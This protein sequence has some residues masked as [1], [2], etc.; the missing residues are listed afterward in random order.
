MET[1]KRQKQLNFYLTEQEWKD[2]KRYRA[3]QEDERSISAMIRD[4]IKEK[5]YDNQ[6]CSKR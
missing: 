2:V 6:D 3:R 4:M 5:I 1:V